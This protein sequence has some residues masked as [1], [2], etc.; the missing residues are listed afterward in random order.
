MSDIVLR[1]AR[2][3]ELPE[4]AH[5]MAR[6]FWHDNLFG[7]LI[8]PHREAYPNDMDLYWLRRSRVSFWN[9]RWRFLVAVSKNEEGKEVIAGVAQW[10]RLGNGGRDMDLYTLDPRNLL[11]PLSSFAMRI[12]KWLW[13]SRAAD[14]SEED[15][16]ERAYPCFDKIWDGDRAESWY[17]DQ[18]TVKP[19]F[20]GRRVGQRLVQW[21]L[22]RAQ[23]DGVVASVVAAL[24]TNG[25]YQK[26]GFDEQWGSARDGEGNPLK[27]VE[28]AD[29]FW[30]WPKQVK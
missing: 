17:L 10:A 6:A 13:P 19:S 16:I 22:E 7:D 9:W 5:V 3:S 12:H 21:G 26:C 4:I 24:G 2:Y 18:L 14:P 23:A 25:F 27:D 30:R 29:I 8:H 1:D 20:Q 28:G 15:I 11:A